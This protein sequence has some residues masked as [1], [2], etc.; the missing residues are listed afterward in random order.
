MAAFQNRTVVLV[1]ALGGML[2]MGVLIAIVLHADCEAKDQQHKPG[3]WSMGYE[4]VDIEPSTAGQGLEVNGL[5]AWHVSE[6]SNGTVHRVAVL[7]PQEATGKCLAVYR[8]VDGEVVTGQ[9]A[10][11]N[12]YNLLSQ[13]SKFFKWWRAYKKN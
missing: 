3:E 1:F 10:A 9:L 11:Y 6:A 12:N 4:V 5:V 2:L 7:C 8:T 13:S